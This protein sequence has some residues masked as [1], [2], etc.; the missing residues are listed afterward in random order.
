MNQP[1]Q[2]F[3]NQA[4]THLRVERLTTRRAPANPPALANESRPL[5]NLVAAI[6]PRRGSRSYRSSCSRRHVVTVAAPKRIGIT[7]TTSNGSAD[8]AGCNAQN[9]GATK[10]THEAKS[11]STATCA[12][13]RI[14]TLAAIPGSSPRPSDDAQPAGTAIDAVRTPSASCRPSPVTADAAGTPNPIAIPAP[15]RIT[16]ISTEMTTDQPA[17]TTSFAPASRPRDT[18]R[19]KSPDTV[20]SANS[21]P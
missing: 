4:G 13:T 6:S 11:A 18:G 7:G 1:S 21:L 5:A 8:V 3:R 19:P 15:N 20:P 16:V 14:P 12:S 9:A 2:R 10:G 17:Y